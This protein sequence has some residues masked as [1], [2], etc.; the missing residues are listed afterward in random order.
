MFRTMHYKRSQVED[1]ICQTHAPRVAARAKLL[2]R[3]KRLLDLDRKLE[4]GGKASR[5]KR[6]AFFSEEKPGSGQ[7]ISFE[8]YEAFAL[9][10]ALSLAGQGIPQT[11]AIEIVRALRPRLE[12]EHRKILAKPLSYYADLD[13][14][15]REGEPIISNHPIFLSVIQT[16]A[17][18]APFITNSGFTA[19]LVYGGAEWWK[20]FWKTSGKAATTLEITLTAHALHSNLKTIEPRRKGRP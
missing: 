11:D 2:V 4:P 12:E 5:K 6:Y 16:S 3:I 18:S 8:E 7:E 13:K 15:E 10:L 17:N 20:H 14:A 1:A 19:E 9:D